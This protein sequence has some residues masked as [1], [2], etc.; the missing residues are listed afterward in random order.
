M[1][2]ASRLHAATGQLVSAF[3]R[4]SRLFVASGALMVLAAAWFAV[5]TGTRIGPPL[6]L[7]LPVPVSAAILTFMFLGTARSPHLSMP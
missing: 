5:N 6:L 2:G 4:A 3:G 1:G 7:W